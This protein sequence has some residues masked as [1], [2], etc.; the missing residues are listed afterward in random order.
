MKKK[1]KRVILHWTAG[2]YIPNEHEKECY[3][4]L[5]DNCGEIFKGK[6]KV[7]DNFDC[8][9]GNYATHTGGGNTGSIGIALCGMLGF[10]CRGNIG[11]Y[12]LS[13][14]QIERL[15]LFTA[16]LCNEY[17]LSIN[18][19]TVQTHYEFGLDHPN[20]SSYGKIDLTYLYP[21]EWISDKDIGC[22]LR[23]KIKWYYTHLLDYSDETID[24]FKYLD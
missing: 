2:T 22:Y 17:K 1:A 3:H 6:H 19:Q 14:V 20:T 5:I 4:F 9:D 13:K 18:P 10:K 12:Q 11:N 16:W 15:C 7:S 8:T 24:F 21:Y 23:S